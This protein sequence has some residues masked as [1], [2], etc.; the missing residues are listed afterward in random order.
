MTAALWAA[1]DAG[2]ALLYALTLADSRHPPRRTAAWA[3]GFAAALLPLAAVLALRLGGRTAQAWGVLSCDLP[4][5]L[6]V[7]LLSHKPWLRSLFA[8]ATASATRLAAGGLMM[9]A[10]TVTG[11]P[12]WAAATRL[13][14]YGLYALFLRLS[15]RPRLRGVAQYL[16]QGRLWTA[17][18]PVCYALAFYIL[19]IWP[20]GETLGYARAVAH[21]AVVLAFGCSY[22]ALQS[23]WAQLEREAARS[24]LLLQTG[25]F[26][27][28]ERDMVRESQRRRILRHDARHYLHLAEQYLSSGQVEDGRATL[29]RL[30]ELLSKDSQDARLAVYCPLPALNNVL[31]YHLSL[32]REQGVEVKARV[33]LPG[34]LPA[35]EL[36]LAV[37]L[38]NALENARNALAAAPP[39]SPR[40]LEVRLR[41]VQGQLLLEV[42]NTCPVPPAL[43]PLTG[44]PLASAPGHGLGVRSMQAF[45]RKYG[46]QLQFTVQ[47]GVFRLRLLL[48]LSPPPQT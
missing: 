42:E 30:D 22:A 44:L 27:Q 26:R 34:R 9:A 21:C 25:V 29:A 28:Q 6:F 43:H 24:T 10:L 3:A 8:A 16:A 1:L 46:A 20:G 15:V 19:S 4:I 14:A 2:C 48:P 17:L 45:A 13:A 18:V 41:P 7:S 40:R 31:C 38:S 39:G 32:A 47:D 36:E 23:G 33:N 11:S 12:A 35:D 37:V 5:L